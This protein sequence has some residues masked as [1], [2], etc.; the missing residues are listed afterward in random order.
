MGVKKYRRVLRNAGGCLDNV[1]EQVGQS[2]GDN[3]GGGKE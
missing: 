3:V 2:S 1:G